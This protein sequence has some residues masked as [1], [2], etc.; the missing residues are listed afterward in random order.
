M[1]NKNVFFKNYTI[2][3]NLFVTALNL[4][5]V[6][7]IVMYILCKHM[8]LK[9]LGTSLA[10]QQLK[11]VNVVTKQEYVTSVQDIECTCKMQW[12]TNYPF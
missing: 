5:M 12:Y 10:L 3:I 4:V 1:P 2:D 8:K 6:I 11:E 7:T 9:L